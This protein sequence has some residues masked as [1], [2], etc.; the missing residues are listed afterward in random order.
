VRLADFAM[1]PHSGLPSRG[2]TIPETY[3]RIAAL[4]VQ[5]QLTQRA[6]A[7]YAAHY[8]AVGNG[9]FDKTE[10][11]HLDEDGRVIP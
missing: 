5:H 8:A 6:R 11:T 9:R 7:H 10:N 4:G 1:M 2:T 3:L